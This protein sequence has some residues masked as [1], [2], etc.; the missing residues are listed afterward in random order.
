MS[1]GIAPKCC[2]WG[3]LFVQTN[4]LQAMSHAHQLSHNLGSL[5]ASWCIATSNANPQPLFPMLQILPPHA[6]HQMLI[7]YTFIWSI[8]CVRSEEDYIHHKITT[9]CQVKPPANNSSHVAT[10]GNQR[11][12]ALDVNPWGSLILGLMRVRT[13]YHAD[14]QS[15]RLPPSH[16]LCKEQSTREEIKRIQK[17][18]VDFYVNTSLYNVTMILVITCHTHIIDILALVMLGATCF[19]LVEWAK[20]CKRIIKIILL[21]H[22]Q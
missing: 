7:N 20:G 22:L 5:I 2:N 19:H 18:I 11:L 14:F 3:S 13:W 16:P 8:L 10:H 9:V 4:S 17:Q 15:N 12:G 1:Y 6:S 21:A